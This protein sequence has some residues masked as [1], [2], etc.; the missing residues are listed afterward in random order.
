VIDGLDVD[1]YTALAGQHLDQVARSNL[2]GLG[3]IKDTGSL[4]TVTN[5]GLMVLNAVIKEFLT[6]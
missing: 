4:I 6:A 5:Q 1:R 3:M 2:A